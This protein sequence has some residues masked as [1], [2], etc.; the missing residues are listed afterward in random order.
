MSNFSEIVYKLKFIMVND[1]YELDNLPKFRTCCDEEKKDYNG[2]VIGVLP[3]DF[4]SPSLLSGLDHG[5]GM[6]DCLNSCGIDVVCIGTIKI[7]FNH[8][9]INY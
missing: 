5:S 7:L 6:V 3:G 1:V 4:L 2:T 8:Y 9:F